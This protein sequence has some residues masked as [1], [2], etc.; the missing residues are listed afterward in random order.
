MVENFSL[1]IHHK[2]SKTSLLLFIFFSI[3]EFDEN[4]TTLYWLQK[5]SKL[6]DFVKPKMCDL[7]PND[8]LYFPSGVLH[9]TLNIANYNVFVA[10]FV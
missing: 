1:F 10:N 2:P 5:M 7:K 4:E 3:P 8:I 9:A 6:S